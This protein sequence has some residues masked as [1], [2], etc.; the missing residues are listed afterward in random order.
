MTE[1]GA[2]IPKQSFM[3][4]DFEYG[5]PIPSI[6]HHT[7]ETSIW[8]PDMST[9]RPKTIE[10]TSVTFKLDEAPAIGSVHEFDGRFFKIV[11]PKF[12]H[13][14]IT[15]KNSV[16]AETI[17]KEEYEKLTAQEVIDPQPSV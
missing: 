3:V 14:E 9:T 10:A 4:R 2:E 12:K 15:W 11:E 17:S 6:V 13:L 1:I 5:E 7:N 8:A 16:F